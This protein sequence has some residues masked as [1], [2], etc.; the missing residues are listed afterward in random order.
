MIKNINIFNINLIF[1]LLTM[2]NTPKKLNEQLQYVISKSEFYKNKFSKLIDLNVDLIKIFQELPLTTKQELLQDQQDNPPFGSHCCVEKEKIKRI[3]KTSG[4]TNRPLIIALTENDINTTVNVGKKCFISSGLIENDI[5]VHCLSY[6][7]WMGGFTDHQSLEATGAGVIPFG[8]GHSKNLI[9][10][11]ITL[12]PTA[13]HCTPS[14]LTKLELILKQEYNMVPLDLNLKLG[15]FGA[16]SGLQNSEFRKNIENVWGLKAMNANY[17]MADV[18]SMFGAECKNQNGLHFMGE[19]VI[20]PELI[21][22]RTGE[23]LHIEKDVEGEL[24]LTNLIREA[25]PLIRYRTNDIIKILSTEKCICGQ[26]SFRFEV[27]G[28]SDD[29]ITVKG[30]NVFV[31]VIEKVIIEY[32]EYFTGVFQIHVNKTYPIDKI[33]LK[34]ETK[35]DQILSN[36]NFKNYLIN[37]FKER[38]GIKPEIDF[39]L[40]GALPRAEG[41][42]KKLFRIL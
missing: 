14:Y 8:V 9:D 5:V 1:Q 10:T 13:I 39:V 42:S 34:I 23:L 27:I 38:L 40:D 3:H 22:Y 29:M 20:Y 6:N 30:V 7:M 36:K 18:L 4:T 19:G 24:V 32:L 2:N 17:G 11:I 16:E 15:L 21:D 37:I 35:E 25:Q 33:V 28:R 41:K 26:T 12:K 31:S